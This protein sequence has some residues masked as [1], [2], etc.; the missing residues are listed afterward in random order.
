M[1]ITLTLVPLLILKLLDL[2]I[3][4]CYT[5]YYVCMVYKAGLYRLEVCFK[6]FP[7]NPEK[8]HKALYIYVR[9]KGE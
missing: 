6:W 7:C 8:L 2:V 9:Q 5:D 4:T 3:S 1:V